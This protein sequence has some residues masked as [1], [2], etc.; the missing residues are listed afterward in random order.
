VGTSQ[1]VT[2]IVN[3][4]PAATATPASQA[5]CIGTATSIALSSTVAGTTFSWTVSQSG[6]SGATAGSG[7][8]I[9]QTLNATGTSAGTATYTI[10]PSANSCPGTPITV[11]VTVTPVPVAAFTYSGS[12]FCKTGPNPSPTFSGGGVAG[13]FTSSAGLSINAVT[14]LINLS[15][16]TAGTYTI[17]NTIAAAGGC[18]SVSATATIT[19]TALPVATFS[20]VGSPYCKTGPNPSPVFSGGGVAGTFTAGAGLVINAFSGMISLA[21][22]TAGTYTVTNTIAAANGCPAVTSTATIT[23]TPLPTATFSYTASPYC[24]NGIDPSP[25][26]SG[27]GV[28]GT[29]SSTVGLVINPAT[30][31]INLSSS[32]AG[33]YTV[34]NTIAAASGCPVVTATAAITITPLPI[35]TFTYPGTPYC[36]V[37]FA[38]VTYVGGGVA[39]T[40][41]STAGLSYCIY[42]YYSPACGSIQL[43]SQPILSKRY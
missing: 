36:R 2:V 22:S 19:I 28:A 39:G 40:F 4:I 14:G 37:G 26:F 7:T 33:T 6:T 12:P 3:P 25:T 5:I 27:G 17:T 41:S 24:Q 1:T 29:F 23:I 21:S 35:A 43:C 13:T 15:G 42:N 18:A 34:T 32:I 38:T 8:T 16:S 20:Y 30:G 9:T 10:T 11:T 31:V